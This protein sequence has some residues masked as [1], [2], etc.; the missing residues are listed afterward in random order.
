MSALTDANA[1]S[2]LA[3]VLKL[4]ASSIGDSHFAPVSKSPPHF[5]VAFLTTPISKPS[6]PHGHL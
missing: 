4:H 5:L 3:L 1:Q 2:S 6:G